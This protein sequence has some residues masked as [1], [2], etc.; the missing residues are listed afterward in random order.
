MQQGTTGEHIAGLAKHLVES[1]LLSQQ[2]ARHTMQSARTS[3]T[4]LIGACIRNELIP[5]ASLARCLSAWFGLPL[6]DIEQCQPVIDPGSVVAEKSLLLYQVLPMSIRRGRLVLAVADPSQVDAIREIEFQTG[7]ATDL[8]IV[9]H[10]QLRTCLAK[11]VQG[12]PVARAGQQISV[13]ASSRAL[14]I[15][16]A[17]TEAAQP[18]DDDAPVIR[19]VNRLLVAAVNQQASDIHLEP[20]ETT[21]RVRIRVDGVLREIASPPISAAGRLIARLKI[22]AHLDISERRLPQDGRLR[23]QLAGRPAVDF[24]LSTLPTLW[25][26]KAVLRVL[27]PLRAQL[28]LDQL[29]LSAPQLEQFEAA[30]ANPQ[31]MILVTGP[32]GSGKTVTLYSALERLNDS[33]RNISTAEDPVEITLPGINQV[34][35]KP[36]V[37][38]DFT[39]ALRAF[40]RQDPDVIMIGE[41]RDRLTVDIAVK[42]AQT[43]H[44]VLSTL[45]TNSAA[46][47]LGRLQNMGIEPFNLA[48]SLSLVIAQRLARK[49]CDHCKQP[50][51]VPTGFFQQLA[52]SITDM[53]PAQIYR[54]A[55]CDRCHEGYR[56]RIGI[57]EVV[58]ISEPLS[59]TIIAGANSMEIAAQARKA[60][61]LSLR[62]TAL[63]RMA[64][65]L[66][67][68]EEVTR[69][70]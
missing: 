45:H 32:T 35:I 70:T 57:Y 15:G 4:S 5:A 59:H 24:R 49:L 66:T 67:S 38:L 12:S 46:D 7:K 13:T 62:Q 58:P 11:L 68:L 60:G 9:S 56:G 25:G 18:N 48:S 52:D 53:P 27:D 44:L 55:G 41:I 51:P 16:S 23:L 36:A 29:G 64:E 34:Q 22:M 61:Y 69:V 39:T 31:G 63:R 21:C 28:P 33:R 30:L 26:E 43:G 20:Y 17:S 19:T 50:A 37:G 10:S 1:G 54:A 40:L 42:A 14:S 65:G 3:G 6:L 8:I 47:T 2:Q